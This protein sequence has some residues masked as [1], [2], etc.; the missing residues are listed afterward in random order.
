MFIKKSF[1]SNSN[2]YKKYTNIFLSRIM[3]NKTIRYT[4]EKSYDI[5]I[6]LMQYSK[7][8]KEIRYGLEEKMIEEFRK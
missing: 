5:L 7:G 8:L 1:K 3:I 4:A 2:E 6:N